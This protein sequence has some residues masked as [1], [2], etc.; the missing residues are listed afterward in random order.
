MPQPLRPLI[1]ALARE[2]GRDRAAQAL[3]K[4][5]GAAHLLLF[6]RDPALNVMLP[7]PGMPKTLVAGPSWREL[8]Q[9]LAHEADVTDEVEVLGDRWAVRA[10][11]LDGCAFVLLGELRAPDFPMQLQEALPLLTEV[12][13][14]QQ[15]LRIGVAEA[16]EARQAAMRAHQLAA[17]LDA[18]R[19]AAAEL[20]RQLRIEHQHK[21]EFLAMLAHEL[22]N[23]MA[24]VLTGIDILGRLPPGDVV[25]RDR[26]LQIMNRQM[27]QL[28]HLVDD[29]LDVS[30]VSRGLIE[31]RREVLP[32]DEVLAAAIEATRPLVVSR[33]H[34]VERDARPTGF[35]VSGDRVRLVQ[36]FSNL[37]NNAA[38]YTEPGGRIA[39]EASRAEGVVHVSIRDN[40]VGIPHEML[41]DIFE[42]FRQVPG[43][44]DRAPGG[45]GIGLTLVRTLV[46]LHGG[47]VQAQSDGPGH[48]SEF[49]V[50]LPLVES[51]LASRTEPQAEAQ[52]SA[53]SLHVLVVD[54]NVD[55]AESLADL[56][57][58]MGAEVSVAHDGAQALHLA[59][60]NSPDLV[61]LDIG[62]PGMDG[63][64]TA[65]E[66]R[67][68]FGTGARMIAL[69]GYGSEEDRRRALGSGFDGHLIKPVTVEVIETLLAD[70]DRKDDGS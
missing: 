45:L 63:Y 54:D 34:S 48:G 24:P 17:A 44:L 51:E 35:H 49:I 64:E 27:Q 50:S 11:T 62:L 43:S 20:N 36:V 46:E 10:V 29:L 39:I 41:K 4:A 13:H 42:M 55:A 60:G 8:L 37:L 61:F 69:T 6:V 7:A 1:D 25:R 2:A 21:D 3:A 38:K 5:V 22:R 68:R 15:G 66:W 12:L 70:A 14:A 32:L 58:M 56:L 65:R 40:G 26:Q 57:R 33:H 31:L 16:A 53:V 67:R 23:P 18:A 47:Q 28:T 59:D 9:R 30:R 19:A 52:R